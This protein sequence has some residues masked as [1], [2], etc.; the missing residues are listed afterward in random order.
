MKT[1]HPYQAFQKTEQITRVRA[2]PIHL[3]QLPSPF[4][5]EKG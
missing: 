2:T 5:L 4:K 1:C 3:A